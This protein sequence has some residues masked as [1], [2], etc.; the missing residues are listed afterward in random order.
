MFAVP[1]PEHGPLPT[2]GARGPRISR[3]PAHSSVWANLDDHRLSW[4]GAL[5]TLRNTETLIGR[6]YRKFIDDGRL[7][8]RLL[9]LLKGETEPT[10]DKPVRVNDP[11]YLMRNSST[12]PPFDTE[13]MFQRWGEEDEVFSIDYDGATHEIVRA[14][15]LGAQRDRTRGQERSRR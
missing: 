5:A 9:A 3:P 7:S 10:F 2:S 14:D 15:E 12:P 6:M 1:A 4:R 11:L 8:I 13:P